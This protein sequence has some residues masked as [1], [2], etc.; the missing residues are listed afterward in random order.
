MGIRSLLRNAFGRSRTGGDGRPGLP[1]QSTASAPTTDQGREQATAAAPAAMASVPGAA[2]ES[3]TP[4]ARKA[5]TAPKTPKV[6]EVPV[7]VPA[8]AVTDRV[9][10]PGPLHP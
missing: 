4:E 7:A 6:P 8:Q 10:D 3:G 9:P 1:Q 5:P 2:T